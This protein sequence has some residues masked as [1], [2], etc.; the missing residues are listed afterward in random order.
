MALETW[1][2]NVKLANAN[3]TTGNETVRANKMLARC[4]RRTARER[5]TDPNQV[6]RTHDRRQRTANGELPRP[7]TPRKINVTKRLRFLRAQ[8][9][10]RCCGYRGS[11][12]FRMRLTR[13]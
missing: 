12:L 4:S 3:C 10:S 2:G 8:R 11:D 7:V 9:R 1:C 13:S 5:K 6:H